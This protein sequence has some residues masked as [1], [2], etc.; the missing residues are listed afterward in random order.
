MK[1][2]KIIH[3]TWKTEKIPTNFLPFVNSWKIKNPDW[4]YLLWTD[5]DC[6]KFMKTNYPDFLKLYNAYNEQIK[7]IDAF[8]YF[9]L[10]HY[11]GLYVDIDFEC[12]KPFDALV[13]MESTCI[14]GLEPE[15]H[16]ERL[17]NKE[18]LICNAIMASTRK[19][20]FWKHVFSMLIK[21]KN[22]KDVLDATGPMMLKNAFDTYPYKDVTL[23]PGNIFYPLVDMARKE[24]ALTEAEQKYY[25]DMLTSH[26]F[27]EE[28]YAV[29][30][31]AG[32][33]YSKGVGGSLKRFFT[34][35]KAQKYWLLPK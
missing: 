16:A 23:F 19:H 12:L 32:T 27:P 30:H 20:R 24:L 7:R 1:T 17:Y 11:G 4:R 29:H 34:K 25:A 3:Q 18:R 14:L 9:L 31:W 5:R 33:W 6:K 15:L 2:P 26:S 10:Y 13:N 28:S 35:L 8:R 21:C 22:E